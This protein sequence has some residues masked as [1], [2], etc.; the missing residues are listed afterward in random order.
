VI[1]GAVYV[2]GHR[3]TSLHAKTETRTRKDLA[4]T[5]TTFI[6][7]L[8]LGTLACVLVAAWISKRR[9]E[10]RLQDPAAP[11]SSLAA[12]GPGPNPAVAPRNDDVDPRGGGVTPQGTRA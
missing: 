7:L 12:D 11:R 10:D 1:A 4:M 3:A 5:T 6:A 2:A 9:T 8:S